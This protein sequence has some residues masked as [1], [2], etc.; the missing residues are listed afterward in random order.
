MLNLQ[1]SHGT[2]LLINMTHVLLQVCENIVENIEILFGEINA[3]FLSI[4]SA[5]RNIYDCTP[6]NELVNK[7]T[8][9]FD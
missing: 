1:R 6:F 8:Q 3:V 9:D 5:S 7:A 2:Y 4:G